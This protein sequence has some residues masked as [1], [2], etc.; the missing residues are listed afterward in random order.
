MISDDEYDYLCESCSR[1]D[2]RI[3]ILQKNIRKRL[4]KSGLMIP[5]P[6]E[7]YYNLYLEITWKGIHA[8]E[9]YETF[10]SQFPYVHPK[11]MRNKIGFA[12]TNG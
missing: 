7:N 4:I 9:E 11:I 1:A 8:V 6:K 2:R 12:K 5:S 10:Y 3:M